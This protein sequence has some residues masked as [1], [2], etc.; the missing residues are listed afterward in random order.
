MARLVFMIF[1]G[2]PDYKKPR[3]SPKDLYLFQ[4]FSDTSEQKKS[5]QAAMRLYITFKVQT[6]STHNS[7]SM[8][9]NS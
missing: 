4:N 7:R 9:G 3:T 6:V 1:G 5:L 2:P 8:T